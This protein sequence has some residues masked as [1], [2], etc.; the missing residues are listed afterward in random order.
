V[1]K[2]RVLLLCASLEGTH[3]QLLL[4]EALENILSKVEDVELVGTWALDDQA[5]A[6]LAQDLPDILLI[7]EEEAGESVTSLTAQV[8]EHYPDLPVVRVGLMQNVVRL[9]TSRTLPAR[10]ADLIEAIRDL[11]VHQRKSETKG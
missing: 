1:D 5:L 3:P 4:G 11:P 9:Y 2:R 10:S 8:L 7:A 6:R